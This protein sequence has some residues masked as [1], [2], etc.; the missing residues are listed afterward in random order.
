MQSHVRRRTYT[1]FLDFVRDCAQIFH[2]AK[3]YNR[4]DSVIYQDAEALEKVLGEALGECVAAG[5]I[6]PAHA[7]LPDLGPL[8]PPSPD[9]SPA[10]PEQDVEGG[11]ADEDEDEDEEEDDDDDDD[12]DDD[13]GPG[14]KRRRSS[15]RT[16]KV[17]RG[18]SMQPTPRTTR[19][20]AGGALGGGGPKD[21]EGEEGGG[22]GAGSAG[23]AGGSGA[24]GSGAGG[25]GGGGGSSG[26]KLKDDPRRKRGRPPRVDTPM[27]IRIKN[28]LKA[29]RK[30]RDDDSGQQRISAFEKLPEKK[31]FPE[32]FQE[33][34]NPIALDIVRVC[35]SAG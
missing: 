27:E 28:I 30:L 10:S 12:D 20:R 33:I 29:L 18:G 2:N 13:G 16:R 23:G 19:R 11:S 9:L 26:R 15:A 5:T 24:G 8:P 7:E 14:S 4:H 31:E 17:A 22:G 25:G 3:L 1:A 35:S 21:G 6:P 32:Y 34:K